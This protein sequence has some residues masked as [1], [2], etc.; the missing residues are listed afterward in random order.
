MI[1]TTWWIEEAIKM[2]YTYAEYERE[3]QYKLAQIKP[4]D[5][6]IQSED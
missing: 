1:D 4:K 2:G 6:E 3:R 5:W